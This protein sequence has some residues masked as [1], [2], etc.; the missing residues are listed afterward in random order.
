MLCTKCGDRQAFSETKWAESAGE[1]AP[2]PPPVPEGLCY[3]CAR[4]D[5]ALREKWQA[6]FK[7]LVPWATQKMDAHVHRAR[8]ILVS[9]LEAI[10]RFIDSLRL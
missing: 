2:P 6:W 8:E 1:G 9:A 7:D 4:D 10:D 5:P 3:R